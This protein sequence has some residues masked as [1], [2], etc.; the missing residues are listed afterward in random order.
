MTAN[1]QAIRKA[2]QV[3]EDKDVLGWV[4]SFTKDGTFRMSRLGSRI[5]G[6]MSSVVPLRFL[7]R[8]SPICIA[9]CT[10]FTSSETR[11]S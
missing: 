10:A 9:N 8:R 4:D 5:A 11:S 1:E 3:A 7:Q 6:Q 2:Y